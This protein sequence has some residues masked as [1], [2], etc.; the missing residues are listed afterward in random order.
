MPVSRYLGAFP[1]RCQTIPSQ[2]C[3]VRSGLP[4]VSFMSL[5]TYRHIST[6][7]L[8]QHSLEF[9][10]DWYI[11]GGLTPSGY[12][13]RRRRK[14][15][16]RLS[17]VQTTQHLESPTRATMCSSSK[18]L[19]NTFFFNSA[20]KSFTFLS[21]IANSLPLRSSSARMPL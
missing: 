12:K 16:E 1:R 4:A 19:L 20:A 18:S 14:G 17:S 2:C 15:N 10:V 21:G 9:L 6:T 13:S 11:F 3:S 8:E 7:C 5:N